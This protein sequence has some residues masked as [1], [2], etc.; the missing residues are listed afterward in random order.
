[1]PVVPG[2]EPASAGDAVDEQGQPQEKE[3]PCACGGTL[4]YQRQR[5]ATV[6]TVFGRV[7]YKRV[8]YSGFQCGK[9]HAPLDEHL[10]LRA[11]AVNLELAQLLA[12]AGIQFS[13]EYTNGGRRAFVYSLMAF[14]DGCL[15]GARPVNE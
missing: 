9:G 11:G 8:Y 4:K 6:I 5:E 1:M 2:G 7:T 15:G 12:L 13:Y 3:I 10:R 14:V